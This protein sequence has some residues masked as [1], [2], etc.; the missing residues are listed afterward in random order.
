MTNGENR[1]RRSGGHCQTGSCSPQQGFT[2]A[3]NNKRRRTNASL[4]S[5][6]ADNHSSRYNRILRLFYSIPAAAN[7]TKER[8]R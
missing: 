7:S 5:L 4:E 1:R 8:R 6:E 3:A 2:W